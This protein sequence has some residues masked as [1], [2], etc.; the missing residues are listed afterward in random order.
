MATVGVD[1]SSLQ[2]HSRP[3]SAGL[4]WGLCTHGPNQLVWSEG[5]ALT[6]Q[7]SWFGLRVMHSRPKSVGLVWG[8]CTHGPSQL[9]WSEGCA[10]IAQISWFG[11]RIVP[12][13]PKSVGLVWGLCTHGPSQLVWSEGCAL[14]AQV[15]W[16]G[17]R[18]D[19]CL[20]QFYI[21]WVNSCNRLYYDTT[22]DTV[23][24]YDYYMRDITNI[25]IQG[26]LTCPNRALQRANRLSC[27]LNTVFSLF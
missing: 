3:K 17:L 5:C 6:A 8:L 21:N 13:R 1:S 11:L 2:V 16:F 12:S 14:M 25:Y 23:P 24:V 10:L 20:A 4:V 19:S 26:M 27:A 7:I 15:S 22:T 18:V 9:V